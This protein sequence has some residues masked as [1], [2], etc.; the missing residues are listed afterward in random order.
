MVVSGEHC[1]YYELSHNTTPQ[2]GRSHDLIVL[3]MIHV[4]NNIF[5]VAQ[6]FMKL[7]KLLSWS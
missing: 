5:I 1:V 7:C 4:S 3:S 2:F 6:I